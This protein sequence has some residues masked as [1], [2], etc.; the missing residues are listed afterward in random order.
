MGLFSQLSGTFINIAAVLLGTLI[1]LTV[2]GRLPERTQ[3]TLLQTLSLVTLFIALDM[4]GSLNKVSGGQVPGV[5]LALITL[6]AGVVVGEALGIEEGL[7]RLGDSL[8]RRFRGG[9]LFTEGFVA[10]SLLFCIGPMTVIGGLQNGLTGDSSTYV[11]KSTLDGIAALALAGAYGIGVGFSTLTILLVQGGISL[12]AGSFA[13]GLLGGADPE[14]L[15]TNP[16]VLLITGVG[17]LMIV[18][19]SWNLMLGGLGMDDK[20][21]RVGSMMPALLLAP[22]GLWLA[23]SLQG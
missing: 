14:I 6:A 4:A 9:G 22:L 11:L 12:A 15:R 21:V 3:R 5:I 23:R 8:K 17:G 20:R 13:A 1:G 10:A 16:Y 18:G 19:I 7:N 2:G